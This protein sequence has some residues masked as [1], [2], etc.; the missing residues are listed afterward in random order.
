M[1][2]NSYAFLFAFLPGTL[3][4][5][6]LLRR[7]QLRLAF[8]VVASYVFYAVDAWW[9]P[10]LMLASTGISF[11][12]GL[13]I[14]RASTQRAR[15]LSL[16]AGVTG[17]LSI[18][19]FFKYAQFLAGEAS[20]VVSVITARGLPSL[21]DW[22]SSIVLPIGISF[23]TFEA[24]SYMADV[25]RRDLEAERSPLHYLLFISFFPHLIAGPI[26]RYSKLRPQLDR[27]ATLEYE[28]ILGGLLLI[29]LGLVKKVV[30]ADGLAGQADPL[31]AS[32]GE[33]GMA[34]AW[35]AMLAYSFQIYFDFA[36]YCDMALGLAAL[37]GIVLPWNFDRPYRATSP[38]EF[39]RR[40]HVTLS[41]WLRDY[42]YFPLGGNRKGERRRDANLLATMGLG[43]LW[44]GASL[45]FVVWGLY[46]G[47]LLV[48]QHRLGR[49]A[50]RVPVVV[51]TGLTFL[52]VT[53]G[54]VFFRM[55]GAAD[56]L[57]VFAAMAGLRGLGSVPREVVPYLVVAGV[58]MWGV[59][60]EW[61]WNL[62]RLRAWHLGPIGAATAVALVLVNGTERFIY[63]KF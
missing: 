51:A 33:I 59:R 17:V 28:R 56:A 3:L 7:Q 34:T 61:R 5:F 18:L 47:L 42:L 14:E 2:F 6:Y 1:L 19:V 10:F 63:F 45:N 46:H 37:F 11:A 58:L 55:E 22:T 48:A 40:W 44:H 20:S 35:A 49:F 54:W 50:V 36:G 15:K 60:E 21:E 38:R 41:S 12:G 27:F 13:A 62:P 25:Y 57:D 16:A 8:L 53:V 26:V 9:F 32:P 52:L 4:V 29:S 24:I 43:G 23:F 30:I 39:W 31:L